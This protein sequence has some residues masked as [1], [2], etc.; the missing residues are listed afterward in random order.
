MARGAIL[1]EDGDWI[2][3]AHVDLEGFWEA[4]SFRLYEAYDIVVRPGWRLELDE[5]PYGEVWLIQDGH[6]TIELR[7]QR[8]VA[9]PGEVAVLAPGGH[10][11]SANEHSTPLTLCGFGFSVLLF[12]AIDLLTRLELQLVVPAGSDELPGLIHEVVRATNGNR[13]DRVFR[14]RGQ[15]ELAFAEI[16]GSAGL[17]LPA[18]SPTE[19]PREEIR[20]AL[21]YIAVHYPDRLDLTTIADA[22][23]LSPKYLARCFRETLGITP[24]A[25]VRRYR[26]ERARD[27]LVTTDQPITRIAHGAGFQDVAHFSRAFRTQYGVNGRILREHSGA[28]RSNAEYFET[29]PSDPTAVTS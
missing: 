5:Q 8:V 18:S 25:Y 7:D 28:L 9:G 24:M 20:A 26:L 21:T 17:D 23:H 12:D 11:V 10:R 1:P 15:A 27:Q 16:V 19:L 3:Q 29:T 13:T 14:A 6:C 4:A 22:V 2:R